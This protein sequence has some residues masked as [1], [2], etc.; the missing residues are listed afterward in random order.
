M[1]L[2]AGVGG[3]TAPCGI[4]LNKRS[5]PELIALSR[6]KLRHVKRTRERIETLLQLGSLSNVAPEITCGSIIGN[7]P[8]RNRV[9][10]DGKCSSVRPACGSPSLNEVPEKP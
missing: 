8:A 3:F 1:V 2:W 9:G 6:N 5:L 4:L 10:S 7:V